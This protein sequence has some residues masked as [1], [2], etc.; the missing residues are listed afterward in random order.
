[1]KHIQKFEELKENKLNEE[2]E[3]F[4]VVNVHID[5]EG[6]IKQAAVN[7]IKSALS[8]FQGERHIFVDDKEINPYN[9]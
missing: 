1:M 7:A 6:W 3:E 5:G 2:V 8:K 9:R 4:G